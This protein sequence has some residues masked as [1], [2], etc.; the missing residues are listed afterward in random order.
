MV[1]VNLKFSTRR[2]SLDSLNN[3]CLSPIMG[4]ISCKLISA[5]DDRHVGKLARTMYHLVPTEMLQAQTAGLTEFSLPL[6]I[7]KKCVLHKQGL[8]KPYRKNN[9]KVTINKLIN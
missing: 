7:A 9:L 2:S 8:I 5:W 6:S 4:R 1:L 3:N